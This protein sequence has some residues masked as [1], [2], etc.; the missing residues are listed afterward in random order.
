MDHWR[1]VNIWL[2]DATG[3]QSKNTSWNNQ[4]KDGRA[5]EVNVRC[6]GEIT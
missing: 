2:E 5:S 6:T 1:P 3:N 4:E